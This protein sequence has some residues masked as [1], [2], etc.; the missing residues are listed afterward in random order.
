MLRL[1]VAEDVHMVR[2]ALVA[3]LELESDLHVVAQV[4]RGDEVLPT[5]ESKRPDVAILDVDLPGVDGLTAAAQLRAS[6]P[7]CRIL[8]L[9]GLAAPGTLRRALAAQVDGFLL[10]D[11]P[12]H[13]LADAVRRAASGER[14][15]DPQLALAAWDSAEQS[16]TPREAE[17]LRLAADGEDIRAIAQELHLTVGTVR[18]YL[19]AVVSKL[20][21]R[22]RIDAV[23][24]ARSSGLI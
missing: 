20:G 12:P 14:V 19:T 24:I 6:L 8:I 9:T 23:R 16:L 22:N 7:E 18:N 10:K 15:I 4:G 3:L 1:I 17:V 21:A 13:T 11:A 5:A 2:G